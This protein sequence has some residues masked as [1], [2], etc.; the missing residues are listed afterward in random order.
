VLERVQLVRANCFFGKA[1]CCVISQVI[2][3]ARDPLETEGDRWPDASENTVTPA[4]FC[5][6]EAF[7]FA[8]SLSSSMSISVKAR[9]RHGA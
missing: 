7:S 6:A 3:V 8:F 1:V 2:A 5:L 9:V 4:A